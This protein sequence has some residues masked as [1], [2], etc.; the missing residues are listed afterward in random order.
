MGIGIGVC[1]QAD[2]GVDP[3]S[4]LVTGL[5]RHIPVSFGTM[6][7]FVSLVQMGIGFVL[8]RKNISFATF[9]ALISVSI[10]IDLYGSFGFSAANVTFNFLLLALGVILYCGGIA[11]SQ[12]PHCGYTAYDC[13]VFGT[14][15]VAKCSYPKAKWPI[16]LLQLVIGYL[17]GG[18]VGLCTVVIVLVS[19][20]LIVAMKKIFMKYLSC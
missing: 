7:L 10:G 9:I 4:V 18:S 8:D 20:S 11:L 14:M 16:D 5:F 6:N 3:M 13:L 15:K 2:L 1:D 12:V 17:L 19:G